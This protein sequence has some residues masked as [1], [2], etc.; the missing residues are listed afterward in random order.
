MLVHGEG[1]KMK[2]LKGKIK[3]SR[4]IHLFLFSI[5]LFLSYFFVFVLF[6]SSEKCFLVVKISPLDEI[7][8]V[9]APDSVTYIELF[10]RPYYFDIK[11]KK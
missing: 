4:L 8:P 5:V 11:H 2:F 7:N 3:A 1:E 9:Y 6:R 10:I